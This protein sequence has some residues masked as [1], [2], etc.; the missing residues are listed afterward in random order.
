[1]TTYRDD[2]ELA[3]HKEEGIR[4][5]M[6]TD[7][8]QRVIAIEERLPKLQ[9]TADSALLL[10]RHADRD[11]SDFKARLNAFQRS[12]NALHETQSA[13]SA[14]LNLIDR[15]LDSVEQ[16]MR[17]G[18]AMMATGQDKI[19]DLLTRVIEDE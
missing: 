10:A 2:S 9:D 4:T 6:S 18:F 15:R 17:N 7:L 5:P 19:T 3:L 11:Q 14:H 8:E 16:T 13:H 1:M 12:L